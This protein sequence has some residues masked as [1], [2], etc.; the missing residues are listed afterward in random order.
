MPQVQSVLGYS[1]PLN[2]VILTSPTPQTPH[3][4]PLNQVVGQDFGDALSAPAL[5]PPGNV[6]PDF[7]NPPNENVYA[8]LAL[9]LGVSLASVVALLRVYARLIHLKVVH[10]ADCKL[11]LNAC[12][13]DIFPY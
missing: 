4:A 13:Y 5:Q 9:I 1:L 6:I 12:C 11:P 2:S 3:M 7:A 10:L 8:Y